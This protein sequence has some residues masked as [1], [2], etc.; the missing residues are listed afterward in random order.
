MAYPDEV[1]KVDGAVEA[2]LDVC[3]FFQSN[4]SNS[5]QGF[6]KKH[7]TFIVTYISKSK[8]KNAERT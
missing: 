1:Q 6:N 5:T 4:A 7:G 2:V 3:A 8:N